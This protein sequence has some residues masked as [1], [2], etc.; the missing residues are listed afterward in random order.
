MLSSCGLAAA[1]NAISHQISNEDVSRFIVQQQH[2]NSNTYKIHYIAFLLMIEKYEMNLM[3]QKENI[4]K[5]FLI[6]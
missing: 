4:S 5:N 3:R 1:I 6:H 2:K